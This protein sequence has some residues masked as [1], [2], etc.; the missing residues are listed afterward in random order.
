M[1]NLLSSQFPN[2]KA[3]FVLWIFFAVCGTSYAYCWDIYMDW[4]LLRRDSQVKFLRSSILFPPIAYYI[5]MLSNLAL[6]VSWVLTISPARIGLNVD[7][8]I[9]LLLVAS[10]EI[11]RRSQWNIYRME[12]E[13]LNNCGQFR[14]TREIPTAIPL[15]RSDSDDEA[16]AEGDELAENVLASVE[17]VSPGSSAREGSP[18]QIVLRPALVSP[19]VNSNPNTSSSYAPSPDPLSP[20]SSP[21]QIDN[22]A[23][24]S[25]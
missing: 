14:V 15:P 21:L 7:H 12:N 23:A 4:G 22:G 5:A 9:V 2:S 8:D 24:K 3:L 17:D 20:L 18:D 19:V 11:I 1:F 10:L 16:I 13:H 6:R 25:D